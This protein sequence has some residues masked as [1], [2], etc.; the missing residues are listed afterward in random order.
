MKKIKINYDICKIFPYYDVIKCYK[1]SGYNHKQNV[2]KNEMACSRCSKKHKFNDCP[3]NED[4]SYLN[5]E[6]C[7]NCLKMSEKMNLQ[8]ESN[9][10]AWDKVC[11]VHIKKVSRLKENVNSFK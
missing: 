4:E 8:L 1:C 9:H 5:P 11:N 10:K 6:A 2:C 3:K 7:I